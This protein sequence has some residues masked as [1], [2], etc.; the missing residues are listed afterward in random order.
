MD[1]DTFRTDLMESGV[2]CCTRS[3]LGHGSIRKDSVQV[4]PM[5][6]RGFE[7][8]KAPGRGLPGH[9]NLRV[10]QRPLEPLK[11]EQKGSTKGPRHVEQRLISSKLYPN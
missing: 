11:R 6:G 3:R 8:V 5:P 7:P 2:V 4:C 9:N 1:T 10:S